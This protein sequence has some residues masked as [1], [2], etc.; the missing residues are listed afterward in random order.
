VVVEPAFDEAVRAQRAEEFADALFADVN[1]LLAGFVGAVISEEISG[2]I[3]HCAVDVVA[4]D[5]LEVFD[6]LFG[7]QQFRSMQKIRRAF[8]RVAA[9]FH[10]GEQGARV[11]HGGAAE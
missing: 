2:L 10:I 4:V 3:P 5:A 7:L 9:A 6:V 8:L 1:A 11:P